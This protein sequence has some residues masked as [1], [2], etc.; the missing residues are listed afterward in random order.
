MAIETV[1]T[2]EMIAEYTSKGYWT[3]LTYRDRFLENVRKYPE[4]IAMVAR[5]GRITYRELDQA[6]SSLA[7]NF[8]ELGLTKEDVVGIQLPNSIEFAVVVF[9]LVKIGSVI[10]AF[11][12]LFRAKE[13]DYILRLTDAPAFII[14]RKIK[15]FDYYRM[16]EEIHP[17]LPQLKHVIISGDDRKGTGQG[18]PFGLSGRDRTGC[19]RRI[20]NR[21]DRRD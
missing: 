7:L 16:V 4:K 11:P 14:P 19:R 5:E 1:I 15:D 18:V 2:Q 17:N 6:S 20:S 8:L 12:S 3:N 9:S 10:V 13:A 21:G